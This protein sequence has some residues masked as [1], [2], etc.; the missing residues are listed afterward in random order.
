MTVGTPIYK[1]HKNM[2]LLKNGKRAD[3]RLRSF[4]WM[5]SFGTGLLDPR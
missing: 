2:K 5:T 4:T 3:F 1:S